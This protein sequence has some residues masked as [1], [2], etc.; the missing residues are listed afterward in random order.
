MAKL[1]LVTMI[2]DSYDRGIDFFTEVLVF[3]LVEDSP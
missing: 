1:A 2:V 3:E